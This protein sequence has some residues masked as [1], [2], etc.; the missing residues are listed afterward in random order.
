MASC[1]YCGARA[2]TKDHIVPKALGGVNAAYNL[3]ESCEPCNKKKGSE[4]PTCDCSKCLRA[5]LLPRKE[6][7][8]E[9]IRQASEVVGVKRSRNRSAY[10]K[11]RKRRYA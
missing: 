2:T 6:D 4:L 1:H 10:Q 8:A 3:V 9:A 7:G 11:R 5:V